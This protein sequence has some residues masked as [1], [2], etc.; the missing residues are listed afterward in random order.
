MQEIAKGTAD[1]IKACANG[2]RF[3]LIIYSDSVHLQSVRHIFKEKAGSQGFEGPDLG[4][5]AG[6]VCRNVH[7]APRRVG[8]CT[9]DPHSAWRRC[10]Q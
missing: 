10:G 8:V 9:V 4:R 6:Q 2:K 1:D 7:E 5:Q 3:V